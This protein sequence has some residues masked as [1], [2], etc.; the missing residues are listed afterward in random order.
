MSAL[1][2]DAAEHFA[3]LK[4]DSEASFGAISERARAAYVQVW[5]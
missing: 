5:P 3:Q 2:V 4:R 1:D